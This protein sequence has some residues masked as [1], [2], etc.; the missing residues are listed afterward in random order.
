MNATI[1][2]KSNKQLLEIKNIFSLQK[3]HQ[4]RV[5]NTTAKERIKKLKKLK[6]V[7]L[8]YRD[9]IK[10]A[11]Y[12]DFRKHPSEADLTEVYAITSEI[13][14]TCRHLKSWMRNHGV[15]TPISLMGS[16]SYIKYEPKG[17]VLIIAPWNFPISL[18]LTPLISAIAAGNTI[19]LKPSEHT[20][21]ASNILK[22]I[23]EK[24][25]PKE[26]V[27]L[28][29]GGVETSTNLLALPFNH[30]FF[31]G[32]PGV[33]KIVMT[34]AA[35]HL[36]SVTLELGGKSPTIVDE[37]ANIDL[38]ARRIAWG[39]Y[40]NNGQICIAPD[41]IFVHE[42]KQEFFIEKVKEYVKKFYS[43]DASNESS[44]NRMVNTN[45]AQRVKSYVEDAVRHGAKVELGANYDDQQDY[46]SPTILTNVS[47][48]AE[49]MKN[50]IFGPVMPVISFTNLD[51]VIQKIN[52]RE[53]PLAL[54]IY[55]SR[56]KNINHILANTRAGGTCI[57]HNL[58]HF[59]NT[60]LPFGGSNN[61]GIGKGHGEFGFKAFSNARGVLKQHI[62]NAIEMLMPPYTDF[63]QK[64]IDLTIKYF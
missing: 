4:Y 27:A 37:T 64:L 24:V 28:F 32:S 1:E 36:A 5:A 13:K 16:S 19:M 2:L 26:E 52:S 42:S 23:I 29:E 20:P 43:E 40:L 15:G 60:N 63:K 46:I 31:T 48:D 21:H 59:F 61:S 25:F 58:V 35:K 49:L 50:E 6:S 57:N 10:E 39:K 9:E 17:V 8:K 41:H 56:K 18:T 44:Y 12:N 51:E 45:H 53:K 33:G 62:P 38:A 14:H 34:A 30:I 22:K 7:V 54:Y 55:S 47:P 11:L 3:E